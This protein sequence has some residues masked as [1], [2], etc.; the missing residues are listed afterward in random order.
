MTQIHHGHAVM[1]MVLGSARRRNRRPFNPLSAY[2]QMDAGTVSQLA[3]RTL[4]NAFEL[5]LGLVKLLLLE[6]PHAFLILFQLL[7]HLG[8]NQGSHQVLARGLLLYS[9]C[10]LSFRGI[11]SVFP[12]RSGDPLPGL[13][14][15][16]RHARMLAKLAGVVNRTTNQ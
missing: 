9:L 6:K 2:A 11:A 10:F 5:Q 14:P 4:H 12:A 16:S 8:V 1:V 7:L 15:R 3:A 13:L